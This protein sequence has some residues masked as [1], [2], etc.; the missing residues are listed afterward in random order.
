MYLATY[1]LFKW[2][3]SC[4]ELKSA[5]I[6]FS[7]MSLPLVCVLSI[8]MRLLTKECVAVILPEDLLVFPLC[9]SLSAL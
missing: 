1:L 2:F 7:S 3:W 8:L 4:R 6:Y 9:D 5:F